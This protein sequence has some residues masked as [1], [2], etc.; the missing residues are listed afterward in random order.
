MIPSTMNLCFIK[1]IM[2]IYQN[3]F[4]LLTNQQILQFWIIEQAKQY[5]ES[6]GLTPS[7]Q[8]PQDLSSLTA[9]VNTNLVIVLRLQ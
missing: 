3:S 4:P 2:T 6:L 5:M 1:V 9:E 8:P 7:K